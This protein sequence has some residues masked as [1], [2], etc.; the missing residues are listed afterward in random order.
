[1][2]MS[3]EELAARYLPSGLASV[4]NGSETACYR[5]KKSRKLCRISGIGQTPL[6]IDDTP[7]LAIT[8]LKARARRA[9]VHQRIGCI[10]VDY[11]QL[12]RS[13]SKRA[14]ENKVLEIGEI[15]S[16]LKE[17]AKELKIPVFACC[18]LNRETEK[19]PMGFPQLSDLRESGSMENDADTV[20]LLWRPVKHC[21][22]HKQRMDVAKKLKIE[23]DNDDQ[24]LANLESYSEAILAKQRNGPVG[25]VRLRF[26]GERTRFHSTTEKHYS[27]KEEERQQA[28]GEV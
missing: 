25:R 12:M 9:A 2:E 17:I 20:I 11:L 15:T 10:V 27:N 6:Y 5:R 18:Q 22:T 24:T 7:K 19:R 4:C 21:A 26:D 14:E 28:L 8:D 1:M 3:Y 23:G 16:G 13:L